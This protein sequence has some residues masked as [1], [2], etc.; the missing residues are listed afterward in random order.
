MQSEI[1]IHNSF[2]AG[3]CI[4]VKLLCYYKQKCVSS[5]IAFKH[6]VLHMFLQYCGTY[7]RQWCS[8]ACLC[9]IGGVYKCVAIREKN[10]GAVMSAVAPLMTKIRDTLRCTQAFL[11]VARLR[12]G[13]EWSHTALIK[14]F[15]S[16]K[17]TL[18]NH[19]DVLCGA[20]YAHMRVHMSLYGCVDR[21]LLEQ[22]AQTNLMFY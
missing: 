3:V 14:M 5:Y 1:C 19:E 9:A 8:H 22:S 4:C 6:I 10:T 15:F 16:C 2:L 7:V 11:V 21:P 18:L 17:L 12:C 13:R 20:D